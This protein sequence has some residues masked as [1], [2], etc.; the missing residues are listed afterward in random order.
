MFA[1]M[2]LMEYLT[3]TSV[4]PLQARF[5]ESESPLASSVGYSFIENRESTVY[6]MFQ[7]VPLDK[8]PTVAPELKTVLQE[9][10]RH[11]FNAKHLINVYFQLFLLLFM[12]FI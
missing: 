10:V 4:S 3:E 1:T 9:I 2:V 8:I 6:L 7:N 11:G 5:V 12:V